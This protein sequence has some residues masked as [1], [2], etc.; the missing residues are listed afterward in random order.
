MGNLKK[1]EWT[2]KQT[3]AWG[4]ETQGT[5]FDPHEALSK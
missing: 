2:K 4:S 5:Q 3:N 1:K